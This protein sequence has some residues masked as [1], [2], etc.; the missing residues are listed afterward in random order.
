M[1]R[2]QVRVLWE[3]LFKSFYS[4]P[5]R[6]PVEALIFGYMLCCG[7][8]MGGLSRLIVWGCFLL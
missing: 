7:G 2:V 6:V 5:L 8:T 4:F 3:V 1:P